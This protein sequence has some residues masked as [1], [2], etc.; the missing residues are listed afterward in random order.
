MKKI[1]MIT[2]II[3]LFCVFL[4][5]LTVLDFAALH[6]IKKDYVSEYVLNYLKISLS[7]DL[8]IGLQ[9]KENG[10]SSH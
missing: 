6:D 2:I 4:F 7:E 3:L 5:C 1:R 10:T 8:H 9:L